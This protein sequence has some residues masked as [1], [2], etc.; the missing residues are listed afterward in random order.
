MK[1]LLLLREPLTGKSVVK[2]G[3]KSTVF[4]RATIRLP[5]KMIC[6]ELGLVSG[7][8]KPKNDAHAQRSVAIAFWS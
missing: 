3:G 5:F 8:R 7:L 2:I 4:Q 6:Q 1:A